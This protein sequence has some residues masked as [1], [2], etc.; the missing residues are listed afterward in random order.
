MRVV[1]RN[2][3]AGGSVSIS[4]D[5]NDLV[6]SSSETFNLPSNSEDVFIL[7]PGQKL[8]AVGVGVGP[9]FLSLACSEAF[10]TV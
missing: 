3:S 1:V 8:Y 4:Y 6:V 5:V 7:A 9:F 10:P 2:V